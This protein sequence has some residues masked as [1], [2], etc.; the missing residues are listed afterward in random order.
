MAKIST[1]KDTK[2]AAYPDQKNA[3][4]QKY[5]NDFMLSQSDD[6]RKLYQQINVINYLLG[7]FSYEQI[8]GGDTEFTQAYFMNQVLPDLIEEVQ[9]IAEDIFKISNNI[10]PSDD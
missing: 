8:R 9:D 2:K 4:H 7:T 6:L 1:N 3:A 5:N 10:C